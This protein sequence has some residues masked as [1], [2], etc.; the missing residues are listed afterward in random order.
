MYMEM[1][2]ISLISCGYFSEKCRYFVSLWQLS[3]ASTTK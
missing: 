1:L 3:T 2:T